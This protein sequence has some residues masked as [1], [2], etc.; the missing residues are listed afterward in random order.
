M[1]SS[2]HFN[3]LRGIYDGHMGT[4]QMAKLSM[5]N[6][7]FIEPFFH[8]LSALLAALSGPL[9][10]EFRADTE[11]TRDRQFPHGSLSEKMP[12]L[13]GASVTAPTHSKLTD[14]NEGE[15]DDIPPPSHKGV[16]AEPRQPFGVKTPAG[17]YSAV[18]VKYPL[19]RKNQTKLSSFPP[20]LL[21]EG[22]QQ[23]LRK[24]AS[25]LNENA[26]CM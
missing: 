2:E 14:E 23:P 1:T 18:Y 13:P 4:E 3:G 25:P 15:G 5:G 22:Q 8:Y 10:N 17:G 21:V 7:I 11:K 20:L 24:S 16:A 6:Q 12:F 19:Q 26:A 9:I